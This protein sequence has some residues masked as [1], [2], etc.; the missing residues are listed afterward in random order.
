MA[1]FLAPDPVQ[2]TFLIPGTNTPANGALVFFYQA[3]TTTKQTVYKDDAGGTSWSNPIVLDSGGNLPSG[4]PVWFEGSKTYKVVWAPSTDT[5]PP[6]SPYRTIDDMAGV[7]DVAVSQS[8]QWISGPTPTYVGGTQ[9]TLSGDQTGDAHLARRIQTVNTGG[10]VYS[11]ITSSVFSAS[12]TAIGVANDS[13]SLD[14]GLS[15]INYGLLTATNPSVGPMHIYRKG[16]NVSSAA[17]TNIWAVVGDF[18]HITGTNTVFSFSSAPYA[19][20]MKD[21][22]FDDAL[23]LVYSSTTMQLP[24]GASVTTAANDRARVRADTAT[25]MVIMD[26]QRASG[27][28]SFPSATTAANQ[29]FAGPASGGATT[30]TFRA[31]VHA[32]L[33]GS[34]VLISTATFPA[35]STNPV[36]NISSTYA[37][38]YI[39]V[40][41][42]SFDQGPI[43]PTIQISTSNGVSWDTSAANYQGSFITGAGAGINSLPSII[44]PD[45]QAAATVANFSLHLFGY[46]SGMKAIATAGGNTANA[47]ST[48]TSVIQHNATSAINAIR[49]THNN[50]S[51]V[52]DAGTY[53]VWGIR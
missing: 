25:N 9:L 20:A 33:S 45:S 23:T 3:G 34:M 18:T 6:A 43:V 10:T 38:L 48:F 12:T 27:V 8:L 2:G 51:G 21:V 26:Y 11:T 30:A 47:A 53:T 46:Q 50:T 35:S 5:D 15:S 32:D 41:G 44:S 42:A 4:S 31:M 7:N 49:F 19:G 28:D 40:V 1:F 24:G 36:L 37:G 14:S 13:G 16:A 52:Y 29:I 39:D 17:T 22:I